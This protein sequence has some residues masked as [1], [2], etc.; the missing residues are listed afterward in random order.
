MGIMS[1]G[2]KVGLGGRDPIQNDALDHPFKC[3]IT[4]QDSRCSREQ[5]YS[6]RVARTHLKLIMYIFDPPPPSLMS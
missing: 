3:S 2:T 4:C 5:N 6:A 1:G